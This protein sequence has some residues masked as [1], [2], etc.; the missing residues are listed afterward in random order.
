M[1]RKRD[2]A[3]MPARL[4]A[5]TYKPAGRKNTAGQVVPELA[6]HK[7]RNRPLPFL[8]TGHEGFQLFGDDT[9]EDSCLRIARN[10]LKRGLPHALRAVQ[11]SGRFYGTDSNRLARIAPAKVRSFRAGLHSFSTRMATA[12]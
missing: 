3:V 4:A 5:D 11:S 7:W 9:V 12:S 1:T 2:Q 6:F 10:V 8:L